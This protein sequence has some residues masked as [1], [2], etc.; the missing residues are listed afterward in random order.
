M[1]VSLQLPFLH[2][3]CLDRQRNPSQEQHQSSNR[4]KGNNYKPSP[5]KPKGH[6][7]ANLRNQHEAITNPYVC[8][9]LLTCVF[10]VNLNRNLALCTVKP[11]SNKYRFSFLLKK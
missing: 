6:G 5:T 9:V 4:L 10:C 2:Q 1:E 8:A 7:H 11:C 3:H